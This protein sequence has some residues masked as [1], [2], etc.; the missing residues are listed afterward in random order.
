MKQ[1]QIKSGEFW[2]RAEEAMVRR[3]E[4]RRVKL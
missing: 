4:G 1:V 2:T 3:R